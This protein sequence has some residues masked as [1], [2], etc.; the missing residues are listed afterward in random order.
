[1][2]GLVETV[3]QDRYGKPR[4][5]ASPPFMEFH[6]NE[7]VETLSCILYKRCELRDE[8][9]SRAL[10]TVYGDAEGGFMLGDSLKVAMRQGPNVFGLYQL[11]EL[12]DHPRVRYANCRDAGIAFFMDSANV[13]YYGLKGDQLYVYDSATDELDSLGPVRM[14][15][16]QLLTEWERAKA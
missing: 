4:V 8:L 13:W 7:E 2:P 15:L 14:A 12:Q 10:S 9:G 16:E 6:W 3:L 5:V 11:G 1:M